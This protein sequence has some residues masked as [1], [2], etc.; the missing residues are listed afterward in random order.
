MAGVYMYISVVMNMG[1]RSPEVN[2][3][4][5]FNLLLQSPPYVLRQDPSCESEIAGSAVYRAQ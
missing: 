3:S 4:V 2:I 1:M 5:F